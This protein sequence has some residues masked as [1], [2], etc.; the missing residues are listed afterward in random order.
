MP[1]TK[2]L[3]QIFNWKETEE[4]ETEVQYYKIVTTEEVKKENIT[5]KENFIEI[6]KNLE[7]EKQNAITIFDNKI[8]ENKQ[9]LEELNTL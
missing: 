3:K 2:E 6:I 5:T 8:N 7:I 9:I 4:I 1:I